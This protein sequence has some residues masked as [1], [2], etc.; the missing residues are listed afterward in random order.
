MV[1]ICASEGLT[2]TIIF[3]R[4]NSLVIYLIDSQL[5]FFKGVVEPV[6]F[7]SLNV[8]RSFLPKKYKMPFL[9][10]TS[11]YL[12]PPDIKAISV[13]LLNGNAKVPSDF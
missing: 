7:E 5:V 3:M 6:D 9:F 8:P 2:A 11:E 13:K 1:C 12:S 10:C 4:V